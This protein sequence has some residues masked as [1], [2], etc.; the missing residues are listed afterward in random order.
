MISAAN[1]NKKERKITAFEKKWKSASFHFPAYLNE[2][3]ENAGIEKEMNKTDLKT[4][5]N[6][7]GWIH[8]LTLAQDLKLIPKFQ[9][10]QA[11]FSF[12]L[13]IA[14]LNLLKK[15]ERSLPLKEK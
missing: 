11:E 1:L 5:T 9:I 8:S 4:K 13:L 15:K 14:N 10:D 12:S 6:F 7:G 3:P 2:W